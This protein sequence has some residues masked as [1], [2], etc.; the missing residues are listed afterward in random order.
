[1]ALNACVRTIL[2]SLS[3]PVI[4]AIDNAISVQILFLQEQIIVLQAQIAAMQVQII[5]LKFVRGLA[6]EVVRRALGVTQLLPLEIIA[7]CAD[8]GDFNINVSQTIERFLG[9]ALAA[10]DEVTRLISFQQE[11]QLVV[12]E[13]QGIIAQY[14]DIKLTIEECSA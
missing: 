7:D 12:D 13:I 11:L 4:K 10:I 6:Q 1:M 2:C 5:P 3:K 8:L 14:K 9:D